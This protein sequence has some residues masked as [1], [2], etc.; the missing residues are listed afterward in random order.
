LVEKTLVFESFRKVWDS[1]LKILYRFDK[2]G[3]KE[4]RK[5]EPTEKLVKQNIKL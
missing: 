2:A 4:F 1:E 3:F 5:K